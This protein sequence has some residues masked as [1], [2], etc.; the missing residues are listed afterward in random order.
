MPRISLDDVEPFTAE[1]LARLRATTEEDIQ[2][3]MIEDDDPGMGDVD[4]SEVRVNRAYPDPR[5]LR[6]QLGMTQEQFANA[7]GLNLW[8]LRDWEQGKSEPEGAARVLLRV[9]EQN[10]D[11]VRRAVR[12]A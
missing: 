10:P 6:R 5:A 1:E 8:T 4:P 2:R 7:F 9:I 12:V 11:A 3:Q